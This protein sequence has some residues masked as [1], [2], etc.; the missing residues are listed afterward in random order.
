MK[1]QEVVVVIGN[2]ESRRHI[3]LNLL[4]NNISTFGCNAI[5]RDF[6]VDHLVCCDRRMV[7]ESLTKYSGPIY[8]R[9]KH[10]LDFRN[11]KNHQ[12]VFPLPEIPYTGKDKRDQGDHWNS[13]PYAILLACEMNF[14]KIFLLGFDLFS[15]NGRIN[16]IYKDSLNYQSSTSLAIDS[17]N[18]IHQIKKLF[19]FYQDR[20]FFVVNE[21]NWPM[22]R[23]WSFSNV[24]KI[25]LENFYSSLH[26]S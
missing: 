2:G 26:F 1:D 4:P 8:T 19:Q 15:E 10:Y 17:S 18:W 21:Y 14:K 22:P 23:L 11:I 7:F 13:G 12:S 3:D 25:N 20:D 24:Q 9:E 16:N 6:F 5:C